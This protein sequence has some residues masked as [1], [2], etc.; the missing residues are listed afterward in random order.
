MEETMNKNTTTQRQQ[1]D[2][3][4]RMPILIAVLLLIA[5][6]TFIGS[7]PTGTAQAQ[8]EHGAIP[9]ITLDS[10]EP[11]QLIINWQAPD[12][13]PTD[14]R[15]MWANTNL[16]FLSYKN[17]NEAERA[18]EYPLAGVTTLT[19]NNL[20]PGDSYKVKIRSR[21]Y[22]A[23]R[24]V[25]K[26][27][28]PWTNLATQRV[29]DYPPAAPTGL[30]TSSIEHDSL[31]L[32]WD[33]PQTTNITGYRVQRGTDASSLH[34]IEPNTGGPSTNYTD[35]TVVAETTYHYA[36]QA[37]SQDGDGA[38]S[39]TS[40]TT[41]AEP[42]DTVQNKPP[43]APTGLIASQV[44]HESSTLTW[45]NPEDDSITGYRVMRGDSATSL[46]T[47]EENTQSVSTRYED[48]TVE[49][50][51]TYH[52]AVVALST[53]GDSPQS[54]SISATTPAAPKSKDPPPQRGG[55]RQAV[56]T[57]I[58]NTGQTSHNVSTAVLAT[59]F[60]TG[61]GT[62]TLSSVG[63]H[64]GL[65]SSITQQVQIYGDAS[66]NPGTVAATMS[67]PG[68]IASGVNTYTA[69]ANTMLSASTTYW[70]V[71]SNSAATDGQGFR[72]SIGTS[73][74]DSGAAAGW[75]IG[76]GRYKNDI[77][78]TSWS[79]IS[80]H[81]R[82]EI[83]GT[84]GTTTN[85][86]PTVANAIPDQS[87]TV[88]TAFSYAFPANTFN[89][90][91]ATDTLT[92]SATKAD[93][94]ALPTW[95]SF[96]AATRTFSGAPQAADVETVSVKV[97]ASDGNGSSVSDTFDVVVRAA[98]SPR[99]LV[100]NTGQTGNSDNRFTTAEHAQAFTTGATS[101]TVTSV[102]IRSEDPEGDNIALKICEVNASI[103]PTT[104]CTDLTAPDA[105]P[106]GLLVFTAPDMAL[107]AS[108]TYS[109]VFSSPGDEQVILDA[110][111][112]DNEDAS[113]LPGWS[114]RNRSQHKTTNWQ[115]RGYDRAII[116]AINGRVPNTPATGTPTIG[117]VALVGQTLSASTF[118][119]ITDPD[120]KPSQFTY[121]WKRVDSD[122]TSNP[123]NIGTNSRTHRLT[124]AEEGKKVR[125][126]V[127]FTDK[128]GNSEGPLTSAAYPSSGTVGQASPLPTASNGTVTQ[129]EDRS[130][131]F[132]TAD[133]NYSS[134]NVVRL[135]S[136][137][138]T[139]LP[140]KGTL[141]GLPSITKLPNGT[142]QFRNKPIVS[143]D[144]PLT[145]SATNPLFGLG[146]VPP[147]DANG[148][149]Y[150]SFK[151]KVNDGAEDS[152]VEYTMTI[153]ITPVNDPAYGGVFITGPAQV[154]YSLTAWTVS[155]GDQD[156]VPPRDQLNYQWKR[157]AADG[158][159]FEANIGAN[160]S[161]YQV[162]QNDVGKKIKLEI[163]FTD[164]EGTSEGPLTSDAFPYIAT[165]TVGEVT[166]ISTMGAGGDVN[167]YGTQDQGQVFTTGTNPTGYTVSS[168]VIISERDQDDD[169]ALK[170][171]EVDGNLHP[172]TTCTDFTAPDNFTA[173]PLV[174][175]AP[176]GTT[177]AGGRTKYMVVMS[178]GGSYI[179]LDAT[180][181]DGF[182]ASTLTGFSI[183]N[184]SHIKISGVWQNYDV[185]RTIRIAVIGTI[186]PP[187]G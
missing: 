21:Y 175:T 76:N 151:F 16:G 155:I 81:H 113:S 185:K 152:A 10:N 78:N 53:N 177:L 58:S 82:F 87:A 43:P 173:G 2:S 148:T 142:F 12:A 112:S 128:S 183:R 47:L 3:R 46:S 141:Y 62:Y 51:T 25:H 182:D 98:P 31:T 28:G 144:L 132:K 96:T 14:Y 146:F 108:T 24:S 135:A 74:L 167:T 32:T 172:T 45:G 83:R 91:D 8:G 174:F 116:I 80:S 130:Y 163:R 150:A 30:T 18:N 111:D 65:Q 129:R 171:C 61:T 88:G 121:Q 1:S 9:S 36:V 133:F 97:T 15:I 118:G 93:D 55:A 57:F 176:V 127:S 50:E 160:S 149:P 60:T 100:S 178:P 71:T 70:V 126:E 119:I 75:S 143:T 162:T 184:R 44:T 170:I 186:N 52:Y 154:G 109:V 41:P 136:V 101:S 66:G 73:D 103:H 147:R 72:V 92:Y 39:T 69:P 33:D 56:T 35:S 122:G 131:S 54:G 123:T 168:V 117:G 84:G 107:E 34:T 22:N 156:G 95:L 114:I 110:T 85:N 166:L 180:A 157:Y 68:T 153:N 102:T 7:G 86:P 4:A 125:V 169:I 37:L 124:S 105:S 120:G 137:K 42:D 140:D 40:V 134:S 181:S 64:H 5:S 187:A 6:M 67:N 164:N 115:D 104:T 89:D 79:T 139:A 17:P 23:D 11:G 161:T 49:P 165:Q 138:I 20:T 145:V 27:S 29:K 106:A 77:A 48:D 63:I 26:S 38:Q 158:T 94:S 159:S 90:A 179:V 59:A 13:E 99:V 19:L